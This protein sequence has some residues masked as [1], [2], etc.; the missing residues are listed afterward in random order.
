MD[1]SLLRLTIVPAIENYRSEIVGF[2]PKFHGTT[3]STAD[4]IKVNKVEDGY[5]ILYFD[6]DFSGV[7]TAVLLTNISRLMKANLPETEFD[8]IINYLHTRR[9]QYPDLSG[10]IGDPKATSVVLEIDNNLMK[11]PDILYPLIYKRSGSVKNLGRII[12]MFSTKTGLFA[13]EDNLSDKT[14]S[15]ENIG[16]PTP[17]SVMKE[18]DVSEFIKMMLGDTNNSGKKKKKKKSKNHYYASSRVLKASS[19]PKKQY[20]RHGVIV[21]NDRSA[22]R[23]DITTVKEFIKDFIPGKS[24]WEKSL[25]KDLC[26]RFINAYVVTK[27]QL[28]DL[29]KKHR[30]EIAKQSQ[31]KKT[32]H[33][34]DFTEKLLYTPIDHWNDPSR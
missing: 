18:T 33:V 16:V 14:Q 23:R 5:S 7:D 8:F 6:T 32:K 3:I 15:Q 31:A 12:H 27:G 10:F 29:E 2:D 26:E 11:K 34:I 19:D 28:K 24:G 17:M 4:E 22:I 21:C 20:K 13:P 25:R 9:S 30:K 1:K